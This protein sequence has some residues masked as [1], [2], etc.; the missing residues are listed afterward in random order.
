VLDNGDIGAVTTDEFFNKK[1]VRVMSNGAQSDISTNI[2]NAF[3]VL[4]GPDGMIYVGSDDGLLKFDP[5]SKQRTVVFATSESSEWQIHFMDYSPDRK[6]LYLCTNS[7][8]QGAI[9]YFDMDATFKPT[10]RAPQLFAEYAGE[11]GAGGYCDGLAV[12]ACGN[13]YVADFLAES[14]FKITPSAIVSTYQKW[15]TADGGDYGHGMGWGA[16][17]GG[18]DPNALYMPQPYNKDTVV[19]VVVGVPGRPR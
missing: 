12:D 5:V 16:T 19:K 2:G 15:S 8:V 18:W 10:T 14:L 1:L 9:Y 17:S 3:G 11:N 6:R 13:L 4:I 7:L